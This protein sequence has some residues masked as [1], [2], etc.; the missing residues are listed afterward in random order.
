MQIEHFQNLSN[1]DP[2]SLG[3]VEGLGTGVAMVFHS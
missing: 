2:Q 3:G 1:I